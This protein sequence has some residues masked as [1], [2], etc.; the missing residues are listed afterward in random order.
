MPQSSCYAFTIT[1]KLS[2]VTYVINCTLESNYFLGYIC[3]FQLILG[4]VGHV[5][6][7]NSSKMVDC[8]ATLLLDNMFHSPLK[9]DS[10][11]IFK[12]S[13]PFLGSIKVQGG[14]DFLLECEDLDLPEQIENIL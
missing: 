12:L 2:L 5:T 7:S 6:N 9:N 4:K 1:V 3:F 13:L 8:F 10:V 11:K 14:Q